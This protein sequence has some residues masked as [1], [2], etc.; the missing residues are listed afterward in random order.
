MNKIIV[1]GT[2]QNLATGLSITELIRGNN[3]VDAAMVTVQLN[4]KFVERRDFD[5]TI[6]KEGDEVDFLYFMGGGQ[7]N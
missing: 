1:N 2:P 6:L 7:E 4:R 3:I 5:T